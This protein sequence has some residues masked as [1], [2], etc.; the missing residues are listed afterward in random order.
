M[1]DLLQELKEAEANMDALAQAFKGK[2]LQTPT[3][4]KKRE[5]DCLQ[6]L[7]NIGVQLDT[8]LRARSCKRLR[9]PTGK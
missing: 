8:P 2:V 1:K 6:A 3:S 4:L 9:K 7:A 5:F